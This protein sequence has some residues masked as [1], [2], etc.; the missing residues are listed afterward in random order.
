MR[1]EDYKRRKPLILTPLR[2]KFVDKISRLLYHYGEFKGGWQRL[3]RDDL[4]ILHNN[5]M[6]SVDLGGLPVM[7]H[8]TDGHRRTTWCSDEDL[9]MAMDKIDAMFVLDDLANL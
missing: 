5:G 7:N 8:S 3:E 9:K 4:L 6:M 2:Q 1:K